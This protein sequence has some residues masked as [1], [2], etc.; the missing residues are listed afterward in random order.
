MVAPFI[1]T[2][3]Y[4]RDFLNLDRTSSDLIKFCRLAGSAP[5]RL[6][7]TRLKKEFSERH[8]ALNQIKFGTRMEIE[9]FHTIPKNI[10]FKNTFNII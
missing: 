3:I 6:I 5:K 2:P 7:G 4:E 9:F 8:F 10:L 1:S